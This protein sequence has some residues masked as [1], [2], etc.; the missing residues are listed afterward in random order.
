MSLPFEKKPPSGISA[1]TAALSDYEARSW[2]GRAIFL[3][4][5]FAAAHEQLVDWEQ[6][7][8]AGSPLPPLAGLTMTVK[9]CF[10]V[11]GWPT[12]CASKVLAHSPAAKQNAALVAQL[13]ACGATLVAQTNMTEFAYG[14]L[15]VNSHFGTPR[16]PLDAQ[17]E[18]V[19]GGSSS[20]AAVAV[21]RG[22]CDI[23]VCSDTSGS[24]RIPAAF[25]GVVG[26]KPSRGHYPADGMKWL[27][28]SFDV[29]GLIT[30]SA[31][32]CRTV[33]GVLK[34]NQIHA[35]LPRAGDIR[36]AVPTFYGDIA[37]DEEVRVAIS[38]CIDV[39]SNAGVAISET[40]LEGLRLG[41]RLA[42]EGRIIAYEAYRQHKGLLER[43]PQL[44]DP[45]IATRLK[46]GEQVPEQLYRDA[47]QALQTCQE[48]VDQELEHFDAFLL[49]TVPMP[50][51]CAS[52]LEEH[53]H[54]L[55][56]NSRSF[57]LTE[58]ANRIDLPSITLPIGTLP[59]GLMLTGRRGTDSKLLAI[60]CV[61]EPFLAINP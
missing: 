30:R 28:T 43:S 39:L 45:L 16:T 7:R 44:Y 60:A 17:Q 12:N 27:S 26:F 21:A 31:Q 40:P 5:R 9:A 20:G 19:A 33:D 49:P 36:L 23:S 51:P 56:V 6:R 46:L 1:F 48:Q 57:S 14:A 47:L 61:L 34:A 32:M 59:V 2:E 11:K 3:A 38:H 55:A 24:A 13:E 10:D 42:T 58:F 25:C 41:T 8:L 4:E 15:G 22:Y 53:S 18:R 35:P 29:P 54:Y 37:I 50:P 52:T